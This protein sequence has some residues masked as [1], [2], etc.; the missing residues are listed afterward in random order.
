[1][2]SG[3]EA[4]QSAVF[5]SSK[6]FKLRSVFATVNPK[7]AGFLWVPMGEWILL[8]TILS[9]ARVEWCSAL[10]WFLQESDAICI[11]LPILIYK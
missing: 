10:P 4:G 9:P 5:L 6:F 8:L 11:T 7:P 1:M 3:R 2:L